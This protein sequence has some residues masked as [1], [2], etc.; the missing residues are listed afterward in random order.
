MVYRSD[1]A[2]LNEINRFKMGVNE[3]LNQFSMEY[4]KHFIL[5]EMEAK[6]FNITSI[7]K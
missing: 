7:I 4:F 1:I 2:N 6:N 5:N 3:Y